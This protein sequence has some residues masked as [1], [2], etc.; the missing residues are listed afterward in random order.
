MVIRIN[1]WSRLGLLLVVTGAISFPLKANASCWLAPQSWGD[2]PAGSVIK[3]NA[4]PSPGAIRIPKDIADGTELYRITARHDS[5]VYIRINCNNSTVASNYYAMGRFI[6]GTEPARSSFTSP[7]GVVYETGTEGVGMVIRTSSAGDVTLGT[8]YGYAYDCKNSSCNLSPAT[9]NITYIFIKTGAITAGSLNLVGLP[10]LESVVG[11]YNSPNSVV[12]VFQPVLTGTIAFTQATCTLA[13]ASKKVDLGKHSAASITTATPV[14]AWVDASINLINCNYGGAQAYK[15]NIT[16]FSSGGLVTNGG[17]I[18]TP[19][20]WNLT[21][22]PANGTGDILD[23]TNGIV[24]IAS[25]ED[26]ATG[27]GIQLS[28]TN[29]TTPTPVKFSPQFMTGEIVAGTNAIM[30]IPLYARYIK[31][32]EVTGGKDN[33]KVIYRVEY[34]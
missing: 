27:V 34:K 6:G 9:T 2:Q 19:A 25:G 29:T 10:K 13:E 12:V 3:M 24:A 16:R 30:K 15:Y 7:L 31:T 11:G 17:T 26:S 33:G 4:A 23:S 18:T 14:T 5:H 8:K 21:L 20:L 1:W 28:T 22:V 32:G